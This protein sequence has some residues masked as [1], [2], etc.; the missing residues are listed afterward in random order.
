M[1]IVMTSTKEATLYHSNVELYDI[2]FDW[3]INSEITWLIEGF[4]KEAFLQFGFNLCGRWNFA[5]FFKPHFAYFS[6][7]K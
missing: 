2:A 7:V 1:V 6:S 4:R 5:I 3:D